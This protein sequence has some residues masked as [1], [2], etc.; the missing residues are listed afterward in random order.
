MLPFIQ[1]I[2][3][4]LWCNNFRSKSIWSFYFYNLIIVPLTTKDSERYFVGICQIYAAK[5]HETLLLK[6]FWQNLGP[7]L[8][9][10]T[11]LDFILFFAWNSHIFHPFQR[12]KAW[13]ILKVYSEFDDAIQFYLV[14]FFLVVVLVFACVQILLQTKYCFRAHS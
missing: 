7:S 12:G 6:I 14:L 8:C 9:K 2:I 4:M 11:L 10:I 5:V 13:D 3:V 1:G